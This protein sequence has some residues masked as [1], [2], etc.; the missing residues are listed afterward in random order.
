MPSGTRAVSALA[1]DV[2]GVRMK[3][4]KNLGGTTITRRAMLGGMA[5]SA[6]GHLWAGTL[7]GG[8]VPSEPTEPESEGTEIIATAPTELPIVLKSPQ[9]GVAVTLTLEGGKVTYSVALKGRD[10]IL[11]SL[12]GLKLD[13]AASLDSYL[14]STKATLSER[15]SSWKPVYGERAVF[16]DSFNGVTL[17]LQETIAPGRRLAVE[18]R[19]YDE[20]VAFRYRVPEQGGVTT[21][22]IADEV[23]EF[24]LA[25][26]TYGWSTKTAQ[27]KYTRALIE[28]TPGA[29]ERPFLVQLP[30]GPWAAIGEA[31]VADYPSMFLVSLQSEPHSLAGKLMGPA[32]R[33]APFAT[34][35]RVVL[36]GEK[37]GELLEHNY[38]LQNLCPPSEETTTDWIH[39]GK[40]MRE[41]TLSTRGGRELVDFAARQKIQYIEYDAG[42]YGDQD[43]EASDATKVDVEPHLDNADPGYRDLNLREV[44]D[45]AKSKDLGVLLYVNHRV[46]E[47]QLEAILATFVRW[48][49]AGI[50]FGFVNVHTQPWTRLLYESIAKV[51]QHRLILDIHDEFRP[52]GMSRTYPHLLTQEGIRGNEEFP[53]AAHSTTLPFTRML[54][55]AADYT[56]CWL[57]PRLKNTWCHQMALA[58]VLY[59]PLQFIYWYDHPTAFTVETTGME[60]FRKLPTVWDDTRVLE[61]LP[62]EFVCI[63]RKKGTGWFMGVLTN[64]SAREMKITLDMLE[65]GRTYTAAIFS[66][67]DGPHDVQKNEQQFR[68]GDVLDLKLHPKGGAA[69]HFVEG[70]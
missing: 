27:G 49:V 22:I 7:P 68:R 35:W 6:T 13:G 34:P 50:K 44:I 11:P 15:R 30:G 41:M 58:V 52:T 29:S 20:G 55:G 3:R 61:G 12:L 33:E 53:T 57:D 51:G 16:P 5:A 40:V 18:F 2:F 31:A 32:H 23:N 37:P 62:G 59:S 1:Y 36:V 24:R 8:R 47:R 43:N 56:Y 26:G 46:M 42:W 19:A 9:G 17:E 69:I 48:G 64:D 45:Y 63:A 66:D 14:R 39:P 38:L 4:R 54:A 60:W 25:P 65:P 28:D 10:V 67:G 21:V 70:V